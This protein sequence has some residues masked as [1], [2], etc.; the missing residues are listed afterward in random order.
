[1]EKNQSKAAGGLARAAKLTPEQRSEIARNAAIAKHAMKPLAAIRKGNFKE[2]FGFDA[3]CYVLNDENKTAVMSQRGIGDALLLTGGG[4]TAFQRFANGKNIKEYLGPELL[5]K[6][7]N[8]I[9]FQRFTGGPSSIEENP[10]NSLSFG[11]QATL[12]IDV[13]QAIVRASNDG[14][15]QHNQADLAKQAGVILG[16]TAKLGIQTLVYKL[17]GYDSTKEEVIAAFKAFVQ[18]EAKKYEKEFPPELYLEWARLYAI[19]PPVRG[20]SWKNKHLTVDHVY[21]PLAKSN[22]KLLALLRESKDSDGGGKKLFQFLNEV[23]TRALRMH[24]GRILEMAESSSD[25]A[26]YEAKIVDRFGGQQGIN[27][28]T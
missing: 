17:A 3:E 23:G 7:E 25:K 4:G 16:A 6:I 18:E 20:K 27:F 11:Y 14:K 5:E 26:A 2:D 24:L 21:Y 10:K 15:L 1:M 19:V 28:A 13:C 8:P 22:G 12:L 9:Q